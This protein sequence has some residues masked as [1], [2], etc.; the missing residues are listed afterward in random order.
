MGNRSG[1]RAVRENSLSLVMSWTEWQI[2]WKQRILQRLLNME[3][4]PRSFKAMEFSG[5]HQYASLQG[6]SEQYGSLLTS[7]GKTEVRQ[8]ALWSLIEDSLLLLMSP[9]NTL[10][11]VSSWRKATTTASFRRVKTKRE[12]VESWEIRRTR[13]QKLNNPSEHH[14][15]SLCKR[16]TGWYWLGRYISIFKHF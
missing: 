2:N 3:N 8:E 14:S 9:L 5:W 4:I 6:I 15:K 12:C 11:F 7:R 16:A 1:G 13:P 10:P